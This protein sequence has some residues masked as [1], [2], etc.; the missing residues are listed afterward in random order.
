MSARRTEV[1]VVA[2]LLAA[3]CGG[4]TVP[5][6]A[7]TY[8]FDEQATGTVFW[9]PPERLPVRYWVDPD[10]G[11][12]AEYVARGLEL[13]RDQFLYGE[14]SGTLVT[15][16]SRADVL[17]VVD[18][19]TPPDVPLTDDPPVIACSGFTFFDALGA[20]DRFPFPPEVHL[21]W[22]Q[23]PDPVDIANCLARVAAHEVGH[24]LGILAESPNQFDLM[25]TN[26]RVTAPSE[27]DRATVQ[28]LYHTAPN[29]LPPERAR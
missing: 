6:R 19:P 10:A 29:A 27:Q 21:Q 7:E 9:W 12:V 17:V 13:W 4:P 5:Q 3:G 24:S 23:G 26:V 16:S 8:A 15:D 28:Q 2:T 20:D 14:F 1:A 11:V 25:N 18:G 22:D